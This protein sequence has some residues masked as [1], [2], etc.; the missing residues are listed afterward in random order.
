MKF[1][2]INELNTRGYYACVGDRAV[3]VLRSY[4]GDWFVFAKIGKHVCKAWP[5]SQGTY[6]QVMAEAKRFLNCEVTPDLWPNEALF[7]A[8]SNA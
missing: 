3:V 5:N 8:S 7:G 4:P 1:T 2:L 6:R